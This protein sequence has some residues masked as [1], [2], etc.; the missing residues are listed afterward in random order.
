MTQRIINRRLPSDSTIHKKTEAPELVGPP[1]LLLL[2][3]PVLTAAGE[4]TSDDVV[5]RKVVEAATAAALRVTP[6]RT[7]E[8]APAGR[9]DEPAETVTMTWSKLLPIAGVT[10]EMPEFADKLMHVPEVVAVKDPKGFGPSHVMSEGK[11][12]KKPTGNLMVI[13]EPATNSL[14]VTKDTVALAPVTPGKGLSMISD[15]VLVTVPVGASVAEFDAPVF[16]P[17]ETCMRSDC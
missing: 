14:V 13:V 6:L 10:V 8:L 17:M 11:A 1:R 16:E 9:G 15:V 2:I 12:L 5:T 3:E 4:Q 7:N